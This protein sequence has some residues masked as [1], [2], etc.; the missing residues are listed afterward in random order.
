MVLEMISGG[1]LIWPMLAS[2]TLVSMLSSGDGVEVATLWVAVMG[3]MSRS[4][5]HHSMLVIFPVD[6]VVEESDDESGREPF[7]LRMLSI[8]LLLWQ[9][10]Q[11]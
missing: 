3:T 11:L 8:V 6:V 9:R 1:R 5:F 2:K 4:I 10:G 7:C